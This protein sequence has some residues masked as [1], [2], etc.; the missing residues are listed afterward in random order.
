[1]KVNHRSPVKRRLS[2]GSYPSDVFASS[3]HHRSD[4][5]GTSTI[6]RNASPASFSSRSEIHPLKLGLRCFT[7]QVG[8]GLSGFRFTFI[9]ETSWRTRGTAWSPTADRSEGEQPRG[10]V[11]RVHIHRDRP[12]LMNGDRLA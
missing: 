8:S 12:E 10:D 2:D 11:I 1:M 4:D 9:K 3:D 7:R 6:C 5:V